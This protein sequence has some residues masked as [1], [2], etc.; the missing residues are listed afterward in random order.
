MT[1]TS[2]HRRGDVL[3]TVVAAAD[4]CRDGRL[5]TDV[6]GVAAT[7]RDDLDLLGALSLRWHTRLAGRIEAE[8][9]AQPLDLEAAVVRAWQ[10]CAREMAG[11]RLVLD[12][13]LAT[14]PDPA[15]TTALAKAAAKEH[16]MLA[17]M[18]GRSSTTGDVAAGV[19]RAIAERARDTLPARPTV[20]VAPGRHS[21]PGVLDGLIDRL[22]A[23]LAA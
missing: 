21:Q 23:A 19:G 13:A 9:A 18:A 3:R 7:F 10:S 14:H 4:Q 6:E 1:W 17:V 11:T 15:V 2:Y 12:R 5:P 16:A 20:A 8:L 22:R